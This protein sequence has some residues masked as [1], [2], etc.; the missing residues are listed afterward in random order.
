MK[1]VK[2]FQLFENEQNDRYTQVKDL[3]S[4]LIEQGYTNG[5]PVFYRICSRKTV[6][7]M[8]LM[9]SAILN[10]NRRRLE[11]IGTD[12]NILSIIR[13]VNPDYPDRMKSTFMRTSDNGGT[14]LFIPMKNVLMA[15]CPDFDFNMQMFDNEK[16]YFITALDIISDHY[17]QRDP[18]EKIINDPRQKTPWLK[19]MIIDKLPIY[20][21]T[22]KDSIEKLTNKIAE[23]GQWGFYTKLAQDINSE[24][25]SIEVE[26]WGEGPFIVATEE[27]FIATGIK[28]SI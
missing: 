8:I 21:I 7:E 11:P 6:K 28:M 2:P 1:Y 27:A 14:L 12:I 9:G 4:L 22:E 23:L 20:G 24:D 25:M 15:F 19:K 16:A 10:N 3:K 17:R 13:K 18:I 26:A 5:A